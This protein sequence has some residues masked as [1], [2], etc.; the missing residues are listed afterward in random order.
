MKGFRRSMASECGARL[1]SWVGAG[2]VSVPY[3][4]LSVVLLL[5]IQSLL[6]TVVH[7]ENPEGDVVGNSGCQLIWIRI[8]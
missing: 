1:T 7:I 8:N 2:S 3:V 4:E 5:I 6:S